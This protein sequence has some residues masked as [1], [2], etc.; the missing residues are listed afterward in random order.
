MSTRLKWRIYTN[1]TGTKGRWAMA[2][3]RWNLY[4]PVSESTLPATG[5][6]FTQ[7]L[8]SPISD[9][10][11]PQFTISLFFL[12]SRTLTRWVP[13]DGYI[14]HQMIIS[15]AAYDEY[16]R[17][18]WMTK[19]RAWEGLGHSGMF[20]ARLS[21][22]MIFVRSLKLFL[23]FPSCAH[24]EEFFVYRAF[25]KFGAKRSSFGAFGFD[26]VL[27]LF[28]KTPLRHQAFSL[29]TSTTTTGI[30]FENVLSFFK[31]EPVLLAWQLW[32]SPGW[33]KHFGVCTSKTR[34]K[35]WLPGVG[36]IEHGRT[37]DRR[38]DWCDSLAVIH[39]PKEEKKHD[40][41]IVWLCEVSTFPHL[42]NQR[43]W[44]SHFL[45]HDVAAVLHFAVF[46]CAD[47]QLQVSH[48]AAR[49]QRR[50]AVIRDITGVGHRGVTILSAPIWF[51]GRRHC[52]FFHLVMQL[53]LLVLC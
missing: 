28:L 50:K 8:P 4:T 39:G 34:M 13:Y 46:M 29:R 33:A 45:R 37:V 18:G 36:E 27:E 16:I 9:S 6:T 11:V 44:R 35:T 17:H 12:F 41:V 7:W 42:Q 24:F 51:T 30:F 53:W 31:A 1:C 5:A 19:L 2:L 52:T 10:L 38:R 14:R 48:A 47:A 49:G 23:F 22:E 20:W 3:E 40:E 43:V 25:V 21:Q 15:M 26:N 32:W